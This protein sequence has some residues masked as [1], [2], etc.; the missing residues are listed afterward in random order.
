M[1]NTLVIS[2]FLLTLPTG[3]NAQW[4]LSGELRTRTE[5]R[6]GA[7]T[8]KLKGNSA[9]VFTSQRSRMTIDYRLARVV[10][11]SSVQDVRVWGQDASTISTADGSKFSVHE[12]WAEI[13]LADRNDSAFHHSPVDYLA[14]KIGRQEL[15]YDDQ[16]LVGGLDWLQQARRHDAAVVKFR[17]KGWQVDLGA[18]FN[19]NTDAFNYNGTFYT[20]A[21]VLPYLKDSKGNLAPAPAGFIPLVNAAGLSDPKGAPAVQG[22]ASTNGGYQDYKALQFLYAARTFNKTRIS[23]LTLA[24]EFGK[25]TNDSVANRAGADTGYIYGK[26]F[27]R[28]GVNTRITAG[29]YLTSHLDAAEALLLTAG[30]YYQTG[31]DRDALHLSAWTSTI[32]VAYAFSGM[33]ATVGW[34]RLSGNNAFSASATNHRFDPLYGTPHKFWGNMDYFYVSTGAPSGGLSNPFVKGKYATKRL[35]IEWA[36]HYFALANHQKAADGRPLKK[37]LGSEWDWVSSWSV[38]NATKLEVGCSLMAATRSMEYAKN[39]APGAANLTGWW[40]YLMITILLN[41]HQNI[42]K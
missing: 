25:Y 30:F 14:V 15:S 24:D 4:Q 19:Q 33:R 20:P 11:H 1:K 27:N 17:K 26:Y 31:R 41:N 36:Y 5:F 42:Q 35:S 23:L 3:I 12:A 21:N 13:V 7:G 8:L 38:N 34:D 32:S 28:K 39:I 22:P 6:D 18:A 16:R 2:L 40:S 10:F 9:S 29:L 37:Y